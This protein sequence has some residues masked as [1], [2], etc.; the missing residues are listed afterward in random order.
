MS[1]TRRRPKLLGVQYLRAVAATMVAYL[2]LEIQLPQFTEFLSMRGHLD[3]GRLK[4]GVDIFFVISGFIMFVTSREIGPGEFAV[5]RIIRIVPLY[6]LLTCALALVLAVQP[7]LFRTT[8]LSAEFLIKSL[9]FIPYANP[10]QGGELAPLLVPGW[11]L[12]FEMFF[13]AI[14]TFVLF[15]RMRYRLLLSA[16]VFCIFL[17]LGQFAASDVP[18]SLLA[19]YGSGQI[20]EFWLGML[21][22]QLYLQDRLRLPRYISVALIVAGFALLLVDYQS[23][24]PMLR[25]LGNG[26]TGF[27]VPSAAI[28]LGVVALERDRAAGYHWLP[29]LL[30]DASYSL[31][32]GHIFFLGL[33]RVIWPR[34][35]LPDSGPLAAVA[36]AVF[37]LTIVL[38]GA[39]ALYK[40]VEMP[41]LDYL[42]SAYKRW[43]APAGLPAKR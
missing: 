27:L 11:T 7:Q 42:Q 6:W 41:A 4:S 20:F 2:H 31:Y 13:Y 14:F 40:F 22:G 30:G 28:V 43:R 38:C 25:G 10:G 26:V 24:P 19:F 39:V 5:R 16:V 34:L 21:I 35:H 23:A 9:L 32:L 33:A 29:A 15:F 3:S 37:S 1:T 18:H 17:A 36:F 8:T 12:N